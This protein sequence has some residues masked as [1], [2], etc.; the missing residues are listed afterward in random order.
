M[1]SLFFSA[2]DLLASSTK[3]A[4]SVT[5]EQFPAVVLPPLRLNGVFNLASL[6]SFVLGLIP[7]S[8]VIVMSTILPVFL[9]FTFVLIGMVSAL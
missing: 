8:L 9:S 5:Y 7:P 2:N 3:A 4:P 6:E 1:G